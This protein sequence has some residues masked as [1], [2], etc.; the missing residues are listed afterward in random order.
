M[1]RQP[2]DLIYSRVGPR[3]QVTDCW[4]HRK[5]RPWLKRY[6]A[7]SVRQDPWLDT[8]VHIVES[9]QNR[10]NLPSDQCPFCVGGLEAPQPYKIKSFVN[11]WPAMPDERCEIV[12]YTRDHDSSLGELPVDHIK[13]IVD[14]WALRTSSLMSRQDIHSV[15]IFENRG[16]EVGATIDH[17]HGQIYAFDHVPQRT[18]QR[19]SRNW[20]PD[21]DQQRRLIEIN[22]WAAWVISAPIYPVSIEIAP[23][24]QVANLSA[25]TEQDRINFAT[26]L[27]DVLQR[28]DQLFNSKTPYMMWINQDAK[29]H[30]ES[31]L[32]VEV[33]SP[34]RDK[35]VSRYIA[36]AEV[37]TGE[38]FNP[39]NPED[40]AKRLRL[41]SS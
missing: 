20:R 35:N 24:K 16:R 8:L 30:S 9:R 28:I 4:Q 41:L 34:W 14:L 2:I 17:P 23:L 22:G 7:Y 13:E 1:H 26:I 3:A 40:L 38:F 10:P 5:S 39:V 36:A 21:S 15:L 33:V 6:T 11:R 19:L 27:K 29:N 31:W 25:L 37:S 32:N 18:S 12:L